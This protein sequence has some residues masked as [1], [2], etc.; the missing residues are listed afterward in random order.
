MHRG[1]VQSVE[2]QSPK[3]G[4]VGSSPSAPAKKSKSKDLDFFICAAG[5]T[6]FARKGNIISSEARTSLPLAAQM[7][8]VE[9][10]PQMMLQQVANDVMLRINDVALRANGI[11]PSCLEKHRKLC[12][13]IFD[14]SV[15]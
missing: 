8:E 2:H 3:L 7:N 6:S 5:T 14:A 4:V 1:V 9:A 13:N 11:S 10:L 12:Y 15:K